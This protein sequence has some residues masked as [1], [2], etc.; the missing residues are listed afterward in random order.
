[1]KLLFRQGRCMQASKRL[2]GLPVC[3]R[4]LLAT[5]A[6]APGGAVRWQWN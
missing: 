3:A 1:M 5:A 6:A 2:T 4:W